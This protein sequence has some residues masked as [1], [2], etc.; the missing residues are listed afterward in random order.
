[1]KYIIEIEDEPFGR[2]D[3]PVIPHG[4]DELWRARG[5]NSLVFDKEGLRRLE[6]Y[7]EQSAYQKGYED[8]FREGR[9]RKELSEEQNAALH[10]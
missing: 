2:N 8:G 1:M 3:D 7:D 10:T 4:M 5:F 6:P 9:T